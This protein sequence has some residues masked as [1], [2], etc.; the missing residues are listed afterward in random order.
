MIGQ[1]A[2][3]IAGLI[4]VAWLCSENRR[5]VAAI[6][7]V[8][9]LAVQFAVAV[10]LLKFTLLQKPFLALG[11]AVDAL[12]AATRA[13]TAFVFGYVGGGPLPFVLDH[14]EN[15]FVLAFQA[16][17]MVLVITA[18]SAV[19]YHWRVLPF[20][21]RVL[22]VPLRRF[23]GTLTPAGISAAAM[24]F[25]GMVESPL[26]IRPYLARLARGELFIL[27][28]GG[29]ATIAGT[30]MVLYATFLKGIV[31][32]PITHLLTASMISIPAAITVARVMVPGGRNGERGGDG[33]PP[34]Q[35]HG[36]MDALMTGT[37]DGVRI[38]AGI[39]AVL[40]VAVAL[41]HL[42]D[43]LLGVLPEV[44]GRALT[45]QR[46]F[47]WIMAPVAW[48]M[49]VEWD[50]AATAGALLG[51]KTVLNE[52]LAYLD[53]ARLA[54]DALSERSR[55]ILTYGLCG[56]SNF[57]SLGILIGGMTAM[58]PDRRA[59]IIG[60]GPRAML[61]GTLASCLTGTVAG[62]VIGV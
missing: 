55:L 46:L 38:L 23:L 39:I 26:L 53:L 13:G 14:P 30:M 10:V 21:I 54:P 2:V 19:L 25:L 20:V 4:A 18:L 29:M 51:T 58:A 17:P 61:A 42:A 15:S 45:L 59:E 1:G 8:A 37:M 62:L 50:Q 22:A 3:G 44:A 60:L 57:G 47:G 52:L 27:M 12:A 7:I 43:G 49:G 32:S 16:L 24:P 35:Y 9:G 41:V 11:H 48:G 6:P 36:T 5:Q 34:S 33:A 56:F 31:P 40:V 28:T